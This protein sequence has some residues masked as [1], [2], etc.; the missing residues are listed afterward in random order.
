MTA[1][2]SLAR[3]MVQAF[4]EALMS[5]EASA[6]C[7]RPVIARRGEERSNSRNGYGGA[8]GTWAGSIDLAVPKFLEEA[9]TSR[10]GS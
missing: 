6:T 7:G 3:A 1:T 4:A 8:V 10:T 2:P 5:A 9:A